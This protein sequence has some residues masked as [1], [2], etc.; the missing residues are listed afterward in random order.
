MTVTAMT[1]F[2]DAI[3][4]RFEIHVGELYC[5]VVLRVRSHWYKMTTLTKSKG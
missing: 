3:R 1:R 4:V 2:N 5:V